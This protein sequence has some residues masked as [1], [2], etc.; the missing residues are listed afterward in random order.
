MPAVSCNASLSPHDL[1]RDE[2][3]AEVLAIDFAAPAHGGV[4][5]LNVGPQLEMD[6]TDHHQAVQST[7]V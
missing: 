4:P 1:L 2:E 5:Q 3:L 7:Q 6:R